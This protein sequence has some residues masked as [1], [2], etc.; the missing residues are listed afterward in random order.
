M[1]ATIRKIEM[2]RVLQKLED[3]GSETSKEVSEE[4][5]GSTG[6]DHGH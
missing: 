6:N 1:N 5:P 4:H 3:E 2:K